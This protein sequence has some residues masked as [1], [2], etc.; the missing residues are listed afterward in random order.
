MSIITAACA[1]RL[2]LRL[3]NCSKS[4]LGIG[5]G[6]GDV[7]KKVATHVIPWFTTNRAIA[8][9]LCVVNELAGTFPS[10]PL[11]RSTIPRN[12]IM[13]DP[14]FDEPAP[15]DAILSVECWTQMVLPAFFKNDIGA[16]VLQ[17][18]FGFLVLGRF[19]IKPELPIFTSSF[20]VGEH[21]AQQ[22]LVELNDTL[23]KFWET[24]EVNDTRPSRTAEENTVEEIFI[25]SHQR[26]STGMTMSPYWCRSL[27]LRR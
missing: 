3:L 19:D 10:Y 14:K 13:A 16:M 21:N 27:V 23:R 17:T 24:E 4:L 18:T 26:Q 2:K 12:A 1:K 11:D 15:I 25:S 5:G 8:A 20:D 9:E 22:Q 7:K 6:A